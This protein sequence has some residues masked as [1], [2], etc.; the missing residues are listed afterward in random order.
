MH[1]GFN[2][3]VMLQCLYSEIFLKNTTNNELTSVITFDG[4]LRVDK[5]C[6]IRVIEIFDLVY[7][8]Q[9]THS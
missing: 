8:G 6:M 9:Y 3:I 4:N 2:H 1:V 5:C 7:A